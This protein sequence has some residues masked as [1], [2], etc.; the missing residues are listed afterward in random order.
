M[1]EKRIVAYI[2]LLGITKRINP[3]MAQNVVKAQKEIISIETLL[4]GLKQDVDRTRDL[5]AEVKMFSDNVCL[6]EQYD[7]SD[8]FAADNIFSLCFNIRLNQ[9]DLFIKGYLLRGGVAVGYYYSSDITIL[10]DALTNASLVEEKAIVPR[11]VAHRTFWKAYNEIKSLFGEQ[12]VS[13]IKEMFLKDADGRYFI[14]YLD[15]WVDLE[16]SKKE[17]FIEHKDAIIQRVKENIG[18]KKVLKKLRWVAD[19]HNRKVSDLFDK[20][21][22]TYGIKTSLFSPP[23]VRNPVSKVRKRIE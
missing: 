4:R 20:D 9:Y 16:C 22:A 3:L 12:K 19:Y 8:R 23:R 10:G 18:D 1:I 5:G 13:P 7:P 6:S 2:D 14:D 15:C 17:F 21:K 11:V